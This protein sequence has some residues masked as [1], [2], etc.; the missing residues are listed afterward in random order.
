MLFRSL[1][2]PV[3]VECA[4]HGYWQAIFVLQAVVAIAGVTFAMRALPAE[5]GVGNWVSPWRIVQRPPVR[6][7]LAAIA[8]HKGSF[9]TTVQLAT[10]WLDESRIVLKDQQGYLWIGLGLVSAAGSFA[11]GRVADLVGKRNFVLGS[12]VVLLLC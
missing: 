10:R 2:L 5:G 7:A 9:F 8:L 4:K 6:Y 12:S 11:L 3:A 1:G